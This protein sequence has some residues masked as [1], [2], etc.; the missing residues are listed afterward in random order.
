MIVVENQFIYFSLFDILCLTIIQVN[1]DIDDELNL[2]W[3]EDE[4]NYDD[5]DHQEN[6]IGSYNKVLM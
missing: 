4:E 1:T 3:S 5:D 6:K 2:E